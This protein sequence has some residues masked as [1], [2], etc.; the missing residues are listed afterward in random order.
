R[1]ERLLRAR[2]LLQQSGSA[3]EAPHHR[4]A[5][6][7]S[8]QVRS[9]IQNVVYAAPAAGGEVGEVSGFT[10]LER[11]PQGGLLHARH[12]APLLYS[13]HPISRFSI[14]S[15]PSTRT[16][17]IIDEIAYEGCVEPCGSA[18]SFAARRGAARG[19]DGHDR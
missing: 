10:H 16:W 6:E 15:F 13:L 7:E 2:V 9:E 11:P 18:V 17:R 5:R 14:R 12:R 4:G 1:D 8:R 19:A 3:Q